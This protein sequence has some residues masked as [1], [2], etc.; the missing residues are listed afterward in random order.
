M[1]KLQYIDGI[2]IRKEKK[3]KKRQINIASQ[4][5]IMSN[6]IIHTHN[7]QRKAEWKTIHEQSI[8]H[9]QIIHSYWSILVRIQT[10]HG[11]HMLACT[12]VHDFTHARIHRC[13]YIR[14]RKLIFAFLHAWNHA[15]MF[16]QV[17]VCHGLFVYW[18]ELT[19]NCLW[20][21]VA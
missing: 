13:T 21:I 5:T 17:C 9:Y 2:Q 8:S 1:L 11:I 18:L 14:A 4:R 10:G 20:F 12:Y 3:K 7:I 16:M 19:Y 6:A 15:R